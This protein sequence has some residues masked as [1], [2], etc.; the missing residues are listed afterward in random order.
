MWQILQKSYATAAIRS[1][2]WCFRCAWS[3][4]TIAAAGHTFWASARRSRR[5]KAFRKRSLDDLS[6]LLCFL[7]K[8]SKDRCPFHVLPNAS[9]QCFAVLH[10]MKLE[11]IEIE[12]E[13]SKAPDVSCLRR[14]HKSQ[15]RSNEADSLYT[16][17]SSANC[18]QNELQLSALLIICSIVSHVPPWLLRRLQTINLVLFSSLFHLHSLLSESLSLNASRS[19]T[20]KLLVA[21]KIINE[22]WNKSSVQAQIRIE[23]ATTKRLLKNLSQEYESPLTTC[24]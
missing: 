15:L 13:A 8:S 11:T 20:L 3:S 22:L 19:F 10:F 14:L 23:C 2:L 21:L 1:Q 12:R 17:T 7:T 24:E 18:F 5:E 9:R 16:K 6:A 4:L